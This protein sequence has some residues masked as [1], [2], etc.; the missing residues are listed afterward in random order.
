LKEE[1]GGYS[2]EAL[3]KIYYKTCTKNSPE[4]GSVK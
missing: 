1:E 2:H 4:T 3:V